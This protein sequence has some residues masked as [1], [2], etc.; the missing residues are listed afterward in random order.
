MML[1][2]A[3]AVLYTQEK[4]DIDRKE[5]KMVGTDDEKAKAILD[6]DPA[7]AVASKQRQKNAG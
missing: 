6:G 5:W 3:R 4:F 2:R 1:L 7:T